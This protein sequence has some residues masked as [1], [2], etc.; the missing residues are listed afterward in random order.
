MRIKDYMELAKRSLN[1]RKKSNRSTVIGLSLGFA[2]LVPV[3]ASL[4]GVNVSL[5]NQLN[6]TPYLL[7]YETSVSDYRIETAD[8][9]Q[10]NSINI[11]GSKHI[12]YLNNNDNVE[13]AIFYEQYPLSSMP[14]FNI[15]PMDIS[16]DGGVFKS[17]N[18]RKDSYYSIID[19]NKS[20]GFFPR[21]LSEY[22][23][24][25]LFL[26]G[27]DR[28][29][30]GDGK[31]QIVLSENFI[32]DNNLLPQDVY[33]KPF[34]VKVDG[35]LN[36]TEDGLTEAQGFLCYNYTVVGII[37]SSIADMYESNNFMGSQMFFTSASVYDSNGSAVLKPYYYRY[38]NKEYERY[39]VFDNFDNREI[40]NTEYM[41][42]GWNIPGLFNKSHNLSTF[43]S[44]CI[45]GECD[46]YAR[47][48]KEI[49]GL[50]AYFGKAIGVVNDYVEG[51]PIFNRYQL[52]FN[53]TNIVTLVLL[54]TSLVL[55]LSALLNMFC[56]IS[57]N[58][59]ERKQYLTM[60]RAIGAKDSDIPK[61]Y[62]TESAILCSKAGIAISVV[63]FLLS[64]AVKL[65]FDSVL[66]QHGV[67]YN[68]SIPWWIIIVTVLS[69]VAVVYFIGISFSYLCTKR[70]SKQKITSILNNE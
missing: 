53:V 70:L 69:V 31:Q 58:V 56:S 48:N 22:Y 25:G 4:F 64:M 34:T 28:G 57:H 14:E 26:D 43:G 42:L 30:D 33:L 8:Y 18:Y 5:Y 3:I 13:H 6:K 21:N 37:K 59:R 36:I 41:M 20:D 2:L 65:I 49:K 35:K 39:L 17:I 47:L 61:L 54:I 60:M 52:V 9:S 50:N 63:G 11:S 15:K 1:I 45:F 10:N 68:L 46:G 29:F 67:S 38:G 24:G 7:Y 32:I 66:K 27:F 23:D 62:M 44:T 40:L 55:G 12:D 51:S 16:V 19:I